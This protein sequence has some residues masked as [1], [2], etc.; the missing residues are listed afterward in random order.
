MAGPG[1]VLVLGQSLLARDMIERRR[2]FD[3]VMQRDFPGLDVLHSLETHG[4]PA[5]LRQVVAEMLSNAPAMSG[6]ST[7]WVAAAEP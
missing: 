7:R 5:T 2:G 1:Q 3:E 4:S 6:A